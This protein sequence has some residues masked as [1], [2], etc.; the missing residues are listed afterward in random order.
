M[1]KIVL[2]E[3]Y[4]KTKIDCEQ[5]PLK[6]NETS[7]EITSLK[8]EI[9][10]FYLTNQEY[11]CA[12]CR[13]KKLEKHGM[14]WDIEHILPKSIYPQFILEPENLAMVCK[15]CNQAKSN[16]NPLSSGTAKKILKYPKKST[17]YKIIHPHFDVYS[18][19]MEI[20]QLG[21]RVLFIPVLGSEK[22]NFTHRVCNLI[23]FAYDYSGYGMNLDSDIKD[24]LFDFIEKCPPG[25]SKEEIKKLSSFMS[26][27]INSLDF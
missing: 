15:A 14:T 1:Q 18:Q 13:Q 4:K 23:R 17:Q 22:G 19:H 27:K 3:K 6:W 20:H 10:E 12:Y 26:T 7:E 8:K 11:K 16:Q 5:N 9:R 24:I 2:P 21:S 25:S